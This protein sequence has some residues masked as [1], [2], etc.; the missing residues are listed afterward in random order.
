MSRIEAPHLMAAIL[1]LAV[2]AIAIT[3]VAPIY[4][5]EI[6]GSVVTAIGMLGMKLLENHGDEAK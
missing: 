1:T 6:V 2:I 5:K 3:L 4:I